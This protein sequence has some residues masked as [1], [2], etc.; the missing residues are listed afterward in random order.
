[1]IN[2]DAYLDYK[3]WTN[4]RRNDPTLFFDAC[5][6]AQWTPPEPE[7]EPEAVSREAASK[8]H[9]TAKP[10][11]GRPKKS[12]TN[13]VAHHIRL[14]SFERPRWLDGIIYGSTVTAAG[15]SAG[16]LNVRPCSVIAAMH[17]K[18]ISTAAIKTPMISER[19]A[20]TVAKAA[21]HAI[22]GVACYLDRHPASKAKL[23]LELSY[24]LAA[25]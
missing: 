12:T 21:R 25:D 3:Q 18:I 14:L 5:K 19:T 6:A 10:Q 7:G 20:Q 24:E 4:K 15:V 11:R 13:P 16:K 9:A 17:L 22:H 2:P 23:D 8:E 1:M